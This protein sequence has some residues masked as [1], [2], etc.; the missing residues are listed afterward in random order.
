[1]TTQE[2]YFY[3][4]VTVFVTVLLFV[5]VAAFFLTRD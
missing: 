5:G 2:L 3:G 4:T 1:M